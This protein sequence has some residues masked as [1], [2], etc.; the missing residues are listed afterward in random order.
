MK[1]LSVGHRRLHPLKT[2]S[3]VFPP[4]ITIFPEKKQSSTTGDASGR[5]ISPGNILRWYVQLSAICAYMAWR[6]SVPPSTGT[7]TCATMFWTSHACSRNT[8]PGMQSH[9]SL[10]IDSD[11]YTHWYHVRHPVT[12]SLPLENS[13]VV[14]TGWCSQTVMAA[15]LRWS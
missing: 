3:I 8:C 13:S 12:T 5:N 9:S 14:H 6:S 11:A 7:S 4:V 2:S 1:R 15:N 10:A